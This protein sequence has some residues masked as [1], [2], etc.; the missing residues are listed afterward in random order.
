MKINKFGDG[1]IKIKILVGVLL[2]FIALLSS[3][4]IYAVEEQDSLPSIRSHSTTSAAEDG[5]SPAINS[6]NPTETTDLVASANPPPIGEVCGYWVNSKITSASSLNVQALKNAGIT[7]LFILTYRSDPISTLKPFVDKFAGTGIRIHAWIICFKDYNGNWIYPEQSPSQIQTI[8]NQITNIANTYKIDGIHL[9]CVRYPGTAYKHPNAASATQTV[10]N[11]VAQIYENIAAINNKDIAGKP[12]IYL[13]AALM[14]ECAQNAY[15]YGQDYAKLAPY[16]DFLVPMIYKGNYNQNRSWIATTTKYIVQAAG[17][18]PV[19]AG[20]LSYY[21]DN[22]VTPLP[23]SDLYADIKTALDNGASG[24]VLFR[25]G[26]I[27][28][29]FTWTNTNPP[30]PTNGFTM[31]QISEAAITVK[32]YIETNKKLPSTVTIGDKQVS[33]PQFLYLLVTTTIKIKNSDPSSVT[34]KTVTGPTSSYDQVKSGSISKTSYISMASKVKSYV[35]S[36]G[37]VPN[38]A[39]SQLGKICYESL[40]YMYSRILSYYNINKVLPNSVTITS[41]KSI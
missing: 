30:Q 11:F 37:R 4:S 22:N 20:I 8:V 21:S 31:T 40:I 35:D 38:Y 14:P 41:W 6:N 16:L 19:V 18:K 34:L 28:S 36:N 17:G 13:S 39:S 7:D 23:L 12:Y 29:G 25:Y 27:K 3:N 26:L 5:G 33:M 15:Y 9:D 10:T 2:L 1:K 24:F 32:N